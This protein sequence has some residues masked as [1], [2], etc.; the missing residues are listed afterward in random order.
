MVA[1]LSGNFAIKIER[2]DVQVAAAPTPYES[3]RK[4]IEF[5]VTYTK[6]HYKHVKFKVKS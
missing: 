6:D 2:L 4:K 3:E 5:K 1:F